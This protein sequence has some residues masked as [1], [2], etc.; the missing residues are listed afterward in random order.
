MAKVGDTI[1]VDGK[2]AT[3]LQVIH[4]PKVFG[5]LSENPNALE[6]TKGDPLQIEETEYLVKDH[7]GVERRVVQ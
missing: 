3:V 2:P 6:L 7:R 5:Q 4:K 1:T